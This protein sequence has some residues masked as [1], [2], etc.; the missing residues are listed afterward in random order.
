MG[1]GRVAIPQEVGW[2]LPEMVRRT[3]AAV[4]VEEGVKTGQGVRTTNPLSGSKG[5]TIAVVTTALLPSTALPST[6]SCQSDGPIQ[7]LKSAVQGKHGWV[8]QL[9]L[10]D[11]EVRHLEAQAERITVEV[12][13]QKSIPIISDHKSM[14]IAG[15]WF[16]ALGIRHKSRDS[17]YLSCFT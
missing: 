3:S 10:L 4:G 9:Q 17:S 16:P 8:K 13:H 1:K 5:I 15:R 14:P 6:D 7:E 12:G 2:G 11:E